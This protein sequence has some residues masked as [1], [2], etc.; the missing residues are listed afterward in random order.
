MEQ[1]EVAQASM[2]PSESEARAR[3]DEDRARILGDLLALA[4]ALPMDRTGDIG[5]PGFREI[6]RQRE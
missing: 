3:T 6:L 5:A 1:T 4:D 2:V